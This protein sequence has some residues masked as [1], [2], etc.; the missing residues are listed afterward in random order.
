MLR[1]RYLGMQT[2][3][4]SALPHPA[5]GEHV[6]KPTS[7]K[8][9]SMEDAEK[10]RLKLAADRSRKWREQNSDKPSARAIDT[11]A[12]QYFVGRSA[13]LDPEMRA[14]LAVDMERIVVDRL[15]SAGFDERKSLETLRHRI[16]ALEQ[17][18]PVRNSLF[19]PKD[20]IPAEGFDISPIS[21]PER[22]LDVFVP[23]R[24]RM[25]LSLAPDRRDPAAI[26]AMIEI[27]SIAEGTVEIGLGD[28]LQGYGDEAFRIIGRIMDAIAGRQVV[29]HADDVSVRTS[30]LASLALLLGGIVGHSRSDPSS[31]GIIRKEDMDAAIRSP[32]PQ[33]RP[34]NPI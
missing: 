30:S 24:D 23:G 21:V 7:V 15:V 8:K 2:V 29:I 31:D 20:S 9:P 14:K 1:N 19:G 6:A 17:A 22:Q 27:V 12:L 26:E 34:K 18:L 32:F 4:S 5:T 25:S 13:A 33:D 10:L 11:E 28:V 3:E 16:D